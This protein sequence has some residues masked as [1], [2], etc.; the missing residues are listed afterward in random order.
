LANDEHRDEKATDWQAS[1]PRKRAKERHYY[2]WFESY[3]KWLA[4]KEARA[5]YHALLEQELAN[6]RG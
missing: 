1:L 6:L 3:M 2:S 4:G 5:E